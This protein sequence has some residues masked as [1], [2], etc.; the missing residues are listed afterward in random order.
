MGRLIV[1]TAAAEQ[2]AA[3]QEVAELSLSHG[4]FL[5]IKRFS[6]KNF[7]VF[8]LYILYICEQIL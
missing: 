1:E 7:I 8:F 6:Q 4:Q 2:V 5:D 3:E